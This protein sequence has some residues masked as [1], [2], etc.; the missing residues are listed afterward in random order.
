MCVCATVSALK[1]HLS[2]SAHSAIMMFPEFVT[3]CRGDIC[4]K[5][6]DSYHYLK[7]TFSRSLSQ[8]ITSAWLSENKQIW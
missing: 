5:V 8:I 6:T 3:E 1:I 4:V 7:M 2:E